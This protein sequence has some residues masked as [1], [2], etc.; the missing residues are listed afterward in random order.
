[1]AAPCVECA[2]YGQRITVWGLLGYLVENYEPIAWAQELIEA[3]PKADHARLAFLYVIASL[4]WLS[5]RVEEAVRYSDSGQT[6]LNSDRGKVPYGIRAL[7]G[8]TYMYIGQ[9]ERT[10]DWVLA[11]VARGDD[12]H[13]SRGREW[14]SR[15]Q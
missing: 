7:L 1:L 11:Q 4:S 9:H 10:L 6:V 12:T 15:W 3:A 2:G 5:G 8:G 13:T 14:S